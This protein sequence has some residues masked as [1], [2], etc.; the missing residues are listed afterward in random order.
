[1]RI[2]CAAAA[3]P[4]YGKGGGPKASEALAKALHAQGHTVRVVVVA[5]KESFEVRDGVEVKTLP[6]L[7]VY[8]NYWVERSSLAKLIWHAL[9]NFNPR[10]FFRMRREIAEFQPDLVLTVSAENVN[11]ATWVAAKSKGCT[12]AHMIHSYFLMCWRGTMFK[13]GKNCE[14]PCWQCRLSSAGKKMCSQ[15]VDGV[16]AEAAH[17]LARHQRNGFFR[18]ALSKVIPASVEPPV[19]FPERD[20]PVGGP[21]R[22]GFLGMVA[23]VKGIE[24]IAAAAKELGDS[25]PFEY[26]I[27][28]DGDP[29]Y[30]E[31]VL[32]RFPKGRSKYLGWTKVATF[33][34]AI[35]VLV[36]PSVWE[37]PFGNVALEALSFGVPAVV[38]RSGALPEIVEPD[39]S[40]LIFTPGD[41]MELAEC[42]RRIEKDRGL[43]GAMQRGAVTRSQAYSK[44]ILAHSLDEFVTRLEKQKTRRPQSVSA[45]L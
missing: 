2:L 21:I 30:V 38:A 23:P 14:T 33:F 28:G 45:T 22:V 13:N 17:S 40:G 39:K 4:P 7:N 43:L 41:H 1:M 16:M 35:D 44:E 15:V 36:V 12:T 27:A 18:R 34:P 19:P 32:S 37:E 9:E 11:V 20:A 10:A 29:D 8:W 42:L 25:A 5:G 24:T 26:V 6:S 31:E 3:Y